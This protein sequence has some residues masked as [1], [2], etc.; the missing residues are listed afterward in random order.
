MWFY[1]SSMVVTIFRLYWSLLQEE[2]IDNL[3]YNK[4]KNQI[5]KETFTGFFFLL[6]NIL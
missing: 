5:E 3:R 1:E 2:L 4:K 6:N